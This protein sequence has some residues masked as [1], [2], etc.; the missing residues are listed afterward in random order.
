MNFPITRPLGGDAWNTPTSINQRGDIVGF[1]NTAPG[2]A[3]HPHAF[4]W[5]RH[6]GMRDIGRLSGDDTSQASGINNAGRIVGQSCDADDACRA[7]VWQDGAMADLQ[8]LIDNGDGRIAGQA[9]T[10]A[11]GKFVAFVAVPVTD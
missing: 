11:T 1:A 2:T 10:L 6:G 4:L 9:L 5:T 8:P 3:F 7:F